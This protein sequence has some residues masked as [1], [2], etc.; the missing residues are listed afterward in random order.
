MSLWMDECISV[1]ISGW[2]SRKDGPSDDGSVKT[3][4]STKS[5][6]FKN[7]PICNAVLCTWEIYN[8]T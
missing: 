7:S 3:S 2:P 6:T 4:W 8:K 1:P 5:S